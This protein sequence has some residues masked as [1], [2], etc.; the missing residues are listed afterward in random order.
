MKDIV[1]LEGDD[2]QRFLDHMK[3]AAESNQVRRMRFAVEDGLKVKVNE[4]VWTLPYG[5][6]DN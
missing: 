4:F 5:K 3:N 2:L 1:I 6:M